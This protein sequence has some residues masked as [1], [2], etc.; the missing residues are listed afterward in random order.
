ML[1]VVPTHRCELNRHVL[2]DL[3]RFWSSVESACVASSDFLV[4]PIPR[5]LLV[6]LQML[7]APNLA[8]HLRCHTGKNRKLSCPR[9]C[10]HSINQSKKISGIDP[11]NVGAFV[12]THLWAI[13]LA[14]AKK[15]SKNNF[16]SRCVSRFCQVAIVA[17]I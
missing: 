3:H 2:E 13:L 12:C 9:A 5:F 10:L 16:L 7:V 11:K 1:S 17:T 15:I 8:N 14:I 4:H 6:L